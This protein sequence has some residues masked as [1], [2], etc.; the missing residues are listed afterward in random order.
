MTIA[1]VLQLADRLVFSKTG[2]HL[3]DLQQVVIQGVW[4][5]ESYSQIGE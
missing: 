4:Q 2:K 5:G 3:D 1:E